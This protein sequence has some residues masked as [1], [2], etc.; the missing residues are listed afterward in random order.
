MASGGLKLAQSRSG[1]VCVI[2]LTGRVDNSTAP[3]LGARLKSLL[4]AGETKVLLDMAAVSYLTSAAFRVLLVAGSQAERN[5]ARFAL[6]GVAGH[7]RDL[8]EIGGLVDSF[9]I[10]GSRDDA[11]AK[12]T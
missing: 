1:S 3:E 2:T 9:T 5:A 12:L 4:D 11:L 10:L 7:V 8:F 6:C